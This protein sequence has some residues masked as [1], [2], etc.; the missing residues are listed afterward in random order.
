MHSLPTE[1]NASVCTTRTPPTLSSRAIRRPTNQSQPF[2]HHPKPFQGHPPSFLDYPMTI[3]RI[4]PRLSLDHSQGHFQTISE[5][6]LRPLPGPFPD[7]PKPLPTIHVSDDPMI[8]LYP[9]HARP[10]KRCMHPILLAAYGQ[11]AKTIPV[12][13]QLSQ[14][15]PSQKQTTNGAKRTE[16]RSALNLCYTTNLLIQIV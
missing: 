7:H 4:I 3:P 9:M 8:Q 1:R 5:P 2:P 15:K 11:R 12:R 16:R 10:L 14:T 13:T 6:F